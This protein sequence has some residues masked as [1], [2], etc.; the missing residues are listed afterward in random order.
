MLLEVVKNFHAP[1]SLNFIPLGLLP[2]VAMRPR[3]IKDD[4]P[5]SSN[6]RSLKTSTTSPPKTPLLPLIES[7]QDRVSVEIMRGCPQKCRF[8]Q[9]V[10]L[11]R[12][13]RIRSVDSIIDAIRSACSSTGVAD[14][15][16][17]SLSS[18]EYP[19]FEKALK[20]ISEALCP[21]GV[22]L[23][24]P[25]LRVNHQLS[26]VVKGLSTKRSSSLT[27]APEAARDEMRRRIAK[28][29]TN[30]DLFAGCRAAFEHGFFR[31][32][33]YF[34]C[35]FPASRKKIFQE[36]SNYQTKYA[37]WVKKFEKMADGRRERLE[38]CSQAAHT[39]NGRVWR[40]GS[41]LRAHRILRSTRRTFSR[42]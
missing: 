28:R 19:H 29:V 21:A 14:A 35:G 7:V 8:C 37:I 12:P 5:D 13:L 9:S 4:V 34:M 17:L 22:T 11:K 38:L 26:S 40:R 41:I 3:P 16:L 32:K 6:Q 33:M 24:V 42:R 31:I 36:S 18:S 23:S 1:T 2:T 39:F 25:S 10:Q 27:V 15:T 30:D 20:T